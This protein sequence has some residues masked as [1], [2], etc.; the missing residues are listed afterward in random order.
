M[1]LPLWGVETVDGCGNEM[2][3]EIESGM[4]GRKE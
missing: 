4:V 3:A 2:R 1:E